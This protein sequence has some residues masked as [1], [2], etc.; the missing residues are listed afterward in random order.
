MAAAL[1]EAL[2]PLDLR[3]AS[4]LVPHLPGRLLLPSACGL[5]SPPHLSTLDHPRANTAFLSPQPLHTPF[6]PHSDLI[7]PPDWNAIHML[8]TQRC[9]ILSLFPFVELKTCQHPAVDEL[10]VS[11]WVALGWLRCHV[12]Q[13]SCWFSHPSVC[14]SLRN[15]GLI[16]DSF[17]TDAASGL[18]EFPLTPLSSLTGG[19][20][21]PCNWALLPTSSPERCFSRPRT[22]PVLLGFA[23]ALLLSF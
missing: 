4:L 15:H 8:I 18:S 17:L 13:V 23:C 21:T 6:S 3:D 12:D 19:T 22:D 14:A 5:T 1:S 7:L 16:L 10:M 20:W 2:F 11:T 9:E